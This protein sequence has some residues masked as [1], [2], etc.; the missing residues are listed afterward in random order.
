MDKPWYCSS[1]D[2][3][4]TLEIEG[5]FSENSFESPLF[6]ANKAFLKYCS[7]DIYLGDVGGDKMGVTK[8]GKH[9]RG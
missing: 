3:Q 9:F 2:Y 1:K 6:D 4:D 7:S 8:W 5:L